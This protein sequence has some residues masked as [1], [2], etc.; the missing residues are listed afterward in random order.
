MSHDIRSFKLSYPTFT[1]AANTGLD[2]N[3]NM[4]CS[5][6]NLF[7]HYLFCTA[8]DDG[9]AFTVEFNGFLTEYGL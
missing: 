9:S 2:T 8:E 7:A 1:M 6:F 3:G 5:S 4:L